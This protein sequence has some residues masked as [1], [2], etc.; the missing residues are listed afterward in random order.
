MATKFQ[1]RPSQFLG[2][3]DTLQAF[4]FDKAVFYFGSTIEADL[5]EYTKDRSTKNPDKPEVKKRKREMRLAVWLTEPNEE[6]KPKFRDPN[7]EL[8]G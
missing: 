4:F 7:V 3:S 2:I 6:G 8:R 5:E 1:T